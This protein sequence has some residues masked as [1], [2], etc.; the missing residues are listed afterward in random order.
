MTRANP[1]V[2]VDEYLEYLFL[3]VYTFEAIIKIIARGFWS[4]KLAY[5]RDPWNWLD[6]FVIVTAYITESL[7][8]FQLLGNT[9]TGAQP[10]ILKVFRVFRVLKTM[11][12][13]PGLRS[14]VQ[15]L[16]HSI[17]ALKD[18]IVLT[19][20]FLTVF[21]LIGYQL[22]SGTF[23]NKCV[24]FPPYNTEYFSLSGKLLLDSKFNQIMFSEDQSAEIRNNESPERIR[25]GLRNPVLFG[26]M[27]ENTTLLSRNKRSARSKKKTMADFNLQDSSFLL[28]ASDEYRLYHC[29]DTNN[30]QPSDFYLQGDIINQI[31]RMIN[32][33][34]TYR[35]QQ[36]EYEYMVSVA[37]YTRIRDEYLRR[38]NTTFYDDPDNREPPRLIQD[39][40]IPRNLSICKSAPKTNDHHYHPRVSQ[41]EHFEHEL[42]NNNK[43]LKTLLL[44]CIFI[45]VDDF[46]T[47]GFS[48]QDKI[49]KIWDLPGDNAYAVGKYRESL[50][51]DDYHVYLDQEQVL[52]FTGGK[53]YRTNGLKN[54]QK[55]ENQRNISVENAAIIQSNR[56]YNGLDFKATLRI[57]W[58]YTEY[59]HKV[60]DFNPENYQII[61]RSNGSYFFQGQR[62][63]PKF[64]AKPCRLHEHGDCK[65]NYNCLCVGGNPDN[66]LT[67]FDDFFAALLTSFRLIALDAWGRLYMLT[68]H[69]SGEGYV[70]FY[71][72]IV[73]LGSY[74]LINLILAVVYMAYEEEVAAV[75]EELQEALELEAAERRARE[76]EEKDRQL[77]EEEAARLQEME[78][79]HSRLNSN[80]TGYSRHYSI[81][82]SSSIY[83]NTTPAKST[84]QTR[85][86]PPLT[87][88]PEIPKLDPPSE[89]LNKAR[90]ESDHLPIGPP[91]TYEESNAV[92]KSQNAKLTGQTKTFAKKWLN[93]T[94]NRLSV[95]NKPPI[96]NDQNSMENNPILESTK[97]LSNNQSSTKDFYFEVPQTNQKPDLNL[98]NNQDTDQTTMSRKTSKIVNNKYIRKFKPFKKGAGNL[99]NLS[100]QTQNA[101]E[102]VSQSRNIS[103]DV[104]ISRKSTM[105]SQEGQNSNRISKIQ[106]NVKNN[107]H[108]LFPPLTHKMRSS[109]DSRLYRENFDS[110]DR[111][112]SIYDSKGD[113]TNHFNHDLPGPKSQ[114]KGFG[115]TNIFSAKSTIGVNLDPRYGPTVG[116]PLRAKTGTLPF[117]FR[118][119]GQSLI[120]FDDAPSGI[121]HA[122]DIFGRC[123]CFNPKYK[124]YQDTISD[125][126]KDPFFEV[127][128]TVCILMNTLVLSLEQYPAKNAETLEDL[129]FFFTLVFTF[130]M[131]F[132]VLGLT[133]IYY[134]KELWNVFDSCVVII[135]LTELLVSED[136]RNS[137]VGITVLRTF[138]LLRIIKL[139]KSWPTLSK[140]IRII[141]RSLGNLGHLTLVMII[142]LFIFAVVGMQLLRT[143]YEQH[144][145]EPKEAFECWNRSEYTYNGYH[146]KY[147]C[148]DTSARKNAICMKQKIDEKFFFFDLQSE[149]DTVTNGAYIL[150]Q[151][152]ID[153]LAA[154]RFPRWHFHDFP[155]SLMVVFRIICGEW[156][157]CMF[158]CMQIGSP[159]VCV[160]LFILV[161]IIG[162]LVILNLFLALLLN[163]FSG[164][165]LQQI[166]TTDNSLIIAWER[167]KKWCLILK[168]FVKKKIIPWF[169]N[170]LKYLTGWI[171]RG[172]KKVLFCRN[173]L[174]GERKSY[175]SGIVQNNRDPDLVAIGDSD[176]PTLIVNNSQNTDS[177]SV[178]KKQPKAKNN[179]SKPQE[180]QNPQQKTDQNDMP[181]CCSPICQSF[182]KG[183][184]PKFL[185]SKNLFFNNYFM[186]FRK[187]CYRLIEHKTF[188][189]VVIF[190]ILLSSVS[191]V[192]EDVDL[193]SNKPLMRYL[194][195]SDLFFTTFFTIEMLLKWFGY[196]FR[197]YFTNA[198]CLTDFVIVCISILSHKY[199]S[200]EINSESLPGGGSKGTNFSSL[201]VLRTL[202][203]MRPLRALSRCQSMRVVVD[204]LLKAIPSIGNVF[205]VCLIFWLIFS[206][207]GVNIFSGGFGRCVNMTNME[208]LNRNWTYL[209]YNESLDEIRPFK[210]RNKTECLELM[211]FTSRHINSSQLPGSLGIRSDFYEK[212]IQWIIPGVNFD[213]VLYGYLALIQV[214]T[215]MGWIEIMHNAVDVVGKDQQ[216]AYENQMASYV[217]FAIFIV[218]GSF[219][220][221]NLFIGVIIDN[222]NQQKVKKAKDGKYLSLSFIFFFI[223]YHASIELPDKNRCF[224][225]FLDT[226][227]LLLFPLPLKF[228]KI[229]TISKTVTKIE[230]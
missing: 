56:Y 43:E 48:N 219:F 209:A 35:N 39:S 135:S 168:I 74:Y 174:E 93:K 132:K 33:Q 145:I 121:R 88:P 185:R 148:D 161:F 124:K 230:I 228:H 51:N 23:R 81:S 197:Y 157:E 25:T 214:A 123:T 169:M 37:N 96:V 29:P 47:I 142:V 91:P 41:F 134:F 59:E 151:E 46:T 189:M 44:Q 108:M 166:E 27:Q 52:P 144:F 2:W 15:A 36:A 130:E 106:S 76:K 163:S 115:I 49:G 34:I 140:L 4:N 12:I 184:V 156:V 116:F 177:I 149:N 178:V 94:T 226:S 127:I 179:I 220:C 194:Q 67:S 110:Y 190:L 198:W 196:G 154:L 152:A 176:L 30:T 87:K 7:K 79:E 42:G 172:F 61:S 186:K 13:V 18:A 104:S 107:N 85:Y 63:R 207:L 11:S 17:R 118:P 60:W 138:R 113:L 26:V 28:E 128:I 3:S 167:V 122:I 158:D 68:L 92:E 73:F 204:A 208:I 171:F 182:W 80:T 21:S 153:S 54:K 215:F 160:T 112:Y 31:T 72:I 77:A 40:L 5:I 137:G 82:S 147:K 66:G 165:A 141:A 213:Q 221:L 100:S 159:A 173:C 45:C 97:A 133:P 109:S 84:F 98:S 125:F 117:I 89:I 192:Y 86:G 217:F 188:E 95:F 225:P 199:A 206:I 58:N 1:P 222:F 22:F 150:D 180:P 195:I 101:R 38:T 131:I 201:R 227:L 71:V 69:T 32:D 119:R 70:S 19:M 162:N 170:K 143:E 53:E 55:F 111:R 139:A 136:N 90:S 75:E 164:D 9:K 200:L 8:V 57:Q 211:E 50:R 223:L 78:R 203:A 146:L 181:D 187:L 218:L 191:L 212:E 14:I 175:Q 65:E 129:N 64:E 62:D 24:K 126:V 210:I 155:H 114:Q 205:L 193:R 83:S 16:L 105:I 20:F 99:L 102:N 229:S 224:R 120:A 216:P 183:F 202:R 10:A 103:Q 6:F